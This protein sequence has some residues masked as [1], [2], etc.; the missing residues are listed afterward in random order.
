MLCITAYT[1]KCADNDSSGCTTLLP[2][3][4]SAALHVLGL[5]DASKHH[6]E[7]E[8][9]AQ[10][11]FPGK[12][13]ALAAPA[14]KVAQQSATNVFRCRLVCCPLS[15]QVVRSLT[16]CCNVES[17]CPTTQECS[18]GHAPRVLLSCSP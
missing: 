18:A 6:S 2:A 14:D 15:W 8:R 4:Y 12:T 17:L 10:F 7:H 11:P 16:S 3:C 5:R 9:C 13:W 1:C